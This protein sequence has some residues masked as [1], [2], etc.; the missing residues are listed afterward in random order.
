LGERRV[1]NAKVVGSTPIASTRPAYYAGRFLL[2]RDLGSDRMREV[3]QS[4]LDQFFTQEGE[5][6]GDLQRTRSTLLVFLRHLGCTFCR[7]A[8][9]D[10][11]LIRDRLEARNVGL[12]C[13]H[14]SGELLA[15]DVFALHHLQNVPRISDTE[16]R[17]YALFQ[18][19][20][21]SIMDVMGAKAILRGVSTSFRHGMGPPQ[22]N[23][24]QMPGAFVLF[25]GKILNEFRHSSSADRPD[26]LALLQPSS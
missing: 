3:E 14:M 24:M 26:Y 10:L 19:E 7:E 22:G 20:A 5:S 2:A 6:L 18:L 9:A 1:R 11:A 17:L 15:K 13:V 12:A 25:N 16:K 4:V 21:G 23:I 8:L